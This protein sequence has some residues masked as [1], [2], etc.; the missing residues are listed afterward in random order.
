MRAASSPKGASSDGGLTGL[1]VTVLWVEALVAITVAAGRAHIAAS[2]PTASHRLYDLS[3][4]RV[5]SPSAAS[6]DH[7][8]SRTAPTSMGTGECPAQTA[9]GWRPPSAWPSRARV[10]VC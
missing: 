2:T 6:H 1:A 3:L 4:I 8:G 9:A 5:R 10:P 7:R